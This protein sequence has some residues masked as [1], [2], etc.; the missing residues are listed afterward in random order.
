[1]A[2]GMGLSAPGVASASPGRA[3]AGDHTVLAQEGSCSWYG[4]R[5]HGRRTSSG[6]K[7]DQKA[8]TAAHP[9]LPFGTE[10][11]VTELGTGKTV[12]VRVNDRGPFTR[13]RVI[14]VSYAAAC[15]L[16]I[17]GRGVADVAL[18]VVDTEQAAWPGTAFALQVASFSSKAQAEKFIAALSPAQKATAV[19]YVKA[20]QSDAR[21]YRVRFGPFEREEMA[22]VVAAQLKRKGLSS[23]VVTED[24]GR[25]AIVAD[26]AA[27]APSIERAPA[28]R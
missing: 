25:S 12:R 8:F 17:I 22:K 20:P 28:L 4:P 14:D 7:F 19:Y 3:A 6:E 23:D 16:G 21:S 1:M 9:S 2:S 26:N 11:E 5:F 24:F 15:S 13:Q 10:V 18:R 27:A